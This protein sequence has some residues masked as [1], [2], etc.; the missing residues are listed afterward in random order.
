VRQ[1]NGGVSLT[2]FRT[3]REANILIALSTF[4]AGELKTQVLHYRPLFAIIY[5]SM[6]L[7]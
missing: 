6:R 3:R 2:D 5:M 4:S 1:L 7:Y